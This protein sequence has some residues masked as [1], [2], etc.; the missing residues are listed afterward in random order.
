[1]P[2][3]RSAVRRALLL[4]EPL[5]SDRD[6]SRTSLESTRIYLYESTSITPLARAAVWS[7]TLLLSFPFR[8]NTSPDW[9]IKEE[10]CVGLGTML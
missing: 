3:Q 10:I 4:A 7:A 6:V 1:M 5:A 2:P 8:Q 9:L